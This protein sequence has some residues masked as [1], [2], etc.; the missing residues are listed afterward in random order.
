MQKQHEDAV[1]AFGDVVPR[2]DLGWAT[3]SSKKGG[4]GGR[5][6][7]AEE[8][9]RSGRMK[10]FAPILGISLSS[11]D[12]IARDHGEMKVPQNDIL[13]P[14]VVEAYRLDLPTPA[15]NRAQPEVKR[16]GVSAKAMA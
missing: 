11:Q 1:H 16:P 14:A 2:Q 5:P 12:E 15:R 9:D 6:R 13:D 8:K 4:H 3:G 7:T 10:P